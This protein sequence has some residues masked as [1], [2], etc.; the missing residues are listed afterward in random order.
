M[1]AVVHDLADYGVG[2]IRD[3]YQIHG[4]GFRHSARLTDWHDAHLL[5]VRSD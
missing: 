1:L 3:Q 5:T 4:G 2:L